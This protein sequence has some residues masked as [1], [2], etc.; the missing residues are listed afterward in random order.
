M[1]I[2][3]NLDCFRDKLRSDLCSRN[4]LLHLVLAIGKRLNIKSQHCRDTPTWTSMQD[5]SM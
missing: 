5:H 4:D 2:A 1:K 3:M